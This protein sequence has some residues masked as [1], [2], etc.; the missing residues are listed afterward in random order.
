MFVAGPTDRTQKNDALLAQR[1]CSE[2]SL[3]SA[4]RSILEV[5][6]TTD[7][8]QSSTVNV[9]ATTQSD[10]DIT[11]RASVLSRQNGSLDSPYATRLRSSNDHC[12][13]P[14]D[15]CSKTVDSIIEEKRISKQRPLAKAATEHILSK[16]V[17]RPPSPVIIY[18][19]P[20]LNDD[21]SESMSESSC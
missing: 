21:V 15:G 2:E 1:T 4:V 13:S 3:V 10:V 7:P 12:T 5:P 20:H 19:I 17:F 8:M 11:P 14:V 18:P 16:V 9:D 6:M